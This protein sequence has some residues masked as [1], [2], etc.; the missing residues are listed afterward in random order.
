MISTL[1]EQA[2]TVRWQTLRPFLPKLRLRKR[3][4]EAE[5][6]PHELNPE[7][8]KRDVKVYVT[9][10]SCMQPL[11][12]RRCGFGRACRSNWPRC[13]IQKLGSV[14][15]NPAISPRNGFAIS[16]GLSS[17][18]NGINP[19]I[20]GWQ[21]QL[22]S[23]QRLSAFWTPTGGVSNTSGMRRKSCKKRLD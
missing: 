9:S 17:S 15:P 12:L 14:V 8:G 6:F 1:N 4:H 23:R 19:Q 3:G 13:L 2:C 10:W 11:A 21:D 16:R 7:F 22:D 20:S 18:S 5:P